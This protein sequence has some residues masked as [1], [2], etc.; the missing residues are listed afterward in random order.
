MKP[1]NYRISLDILESQSQYSLT[2][3]KGETS[4]EIHITL[5]EG[6]V[7]Y[8]IGKDC[9]AVFSGRKPDGNPLENN[10]VIK[11]NTIIY[12]I[13]PQTTSASGLVDCEVKLYGANDGLICSPRLSIIVD[14]RAVGD[15][16][17][18][19]T[20][21]FSALTKLYSDVAAGEVAR[22]DAEELREVAED[23][24]EFAEA[25]RVEAETIRAL[26]EDERKASEE[27]RNQNFEQI[28]TEG[29]A[30]IEA[31]GQATKNANNI[32]AN[33][34]QKLDN[35]DFVG[36]KGEKGDKGDK[37]DT[38]AIDQVYNPTSEN[39]QSG[40]AVEEGVKELYDAN[41]DVGQII[42]G[43]YVD[44][45]GN[46]AKSA[47][48]HRTDYVPVKA[49]YTVK[50]ENLKLQG[51]RSVCVYDE[52]KKFIKVI[53]NGTTEITA[54]VV[55][56]DDACYFIASVYPDETQY[57]KY[58]KPIAK[59]IEK[60]AQA[61]SGVNGIKY[62]TEW[63]LIQNLEDGVYFVDVNNG[64]EVGISDAGILM[65]TFGG[66][67]YTGMIISNYDAFIEAKR[68][69]VLG[70]HFADDVPVI[71]TT[72]V[73]T[74]GTFIRDYDTVYVSKKYVDEQI[75]VLQAQVD[76]IKTMG[77]GS[78]A[79]GTVYRPFVE[80][81]ENNTEITDYSAELV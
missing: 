57:A 78:V 36:E 43:E 30:G 7:P 33:I 9:F 74:D 69:I 1:A 50:F 54:T 27:T 63:T 52:N 14:E 48:N 21:E 11:G 20:S 22:V 68:I 23:G 81:L 67:I 3:K 75:A 51:L 47:G 37:G 24:R 45:N 53:A 5:R 13:T 19:S 61:M 41:I 2:M 39:A 26:S 46:I 70:N 16:E 55:I 76:E 6:G 18:E 65:D 58:V 80:E 28:M 4:R 29:T 25:G 59:D 8:E 72:F 64:G 42:E 73:N 56:P 15:N 38:P 32:V 10:C 40:I 12:S 17:V 66:S 60:L 79:D 31:L 49:G 35:G 71:V 62:I 77:T 34:Q 44:Y